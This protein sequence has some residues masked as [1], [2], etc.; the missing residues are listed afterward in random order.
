M[1]MPRHPDQDDAV[2]VRR[3]PS[4]KTRAVIALLAA[5]LIVLIG[6]HLAGVLG[7]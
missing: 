4:G 6:L 5:L 3:A 1:G 2:S 7:A